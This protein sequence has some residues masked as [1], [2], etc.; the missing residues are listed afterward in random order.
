MDINSALADRAG[1]IFARFEFNQ[2][3]AKKKS[4]KLDINIEIPG[5]GITTI[6]GHS[7]SG[8]TTFLRCVAGLEKPDNGYLSVN[9]SI[10]QNKSHFVPTYQRPLG[11]VFQES[12][13]FPH[14][15]AEGNLKYAIK[16]SGVTGDDQLYAQVMAIM[17]IE[18]VLKRYPSQLSGGERQ[19]VA[20]ARALLIRPRLLLMDEPLASLDTKRKQEI[21]PYLER[22][23]SFDIPILYVSHSLDEITRLADH[24]VMLEEGKVVAQGNIKEVFSRLDLPLYCFEEPGAILNGKIISRD[25]QWHLMRM[26]FDSGELFLHDVGLEVG[27]PIRVRILAKDVSLSLTNHQDTSILNRIQ[28][29]VIE[30]NADQ[31]EAMSLVRLKA[32]GEFLIAKLTRR[33]VHCLEIKPGKKVW[34]QIKSVAIVR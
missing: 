3:K 26:T 30:I 10:W 16:R 17:E 18:T 28:A 22:L 23:R 21:L 27:Q 34:A 7:G 14:L 20:I 2:T 31:D 8:K 33:S 25:L 4:F 29:E 11:Y 1:V 24:V 9:G 32:G 19:R 12:S 13:L 6:Y 5:K 15:T